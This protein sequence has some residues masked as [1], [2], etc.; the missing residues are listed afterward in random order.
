M[1]SAEAAKRDVVTP[2]DRRRVLNNLKAEICRIFD[3]PDKAL[4]GRRRDR[5]VMTPRQL[6]IFISDEI[7][8]CTSEELGDFMDR[9][10]STVI[11][12]RQRIRDLIYTRDQIFID[13]LNRYQQFAK[14]ELRSTAMW[15]NNVKEH[16]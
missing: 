3:L 6:F 4:F 1:I 10:H 2:Q 14:P 16:T 8:R 9:D 15:I 12:S 7:C 5:E 13:Y 11:V